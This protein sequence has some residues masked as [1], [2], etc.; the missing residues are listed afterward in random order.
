MV[1]HPDW[2]AQVVRASSLIL[3]GCK[4]S[5]Q[6]GHIKE[7]INEC[8]NNKS[9]SLSPLSLSLRLPPLSFPSNINL[10]KK[11]KKEGLSQG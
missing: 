5:P 2:G 6:S 11:E 1:C 9:T 10:K 4:F 3:Q 7:S 8:I